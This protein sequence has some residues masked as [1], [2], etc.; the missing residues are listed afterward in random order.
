MHR[1]GKSGCEISIDHYTE[2]VT[3]NGYENGIKDN[4]MLEYRLQ[5]KDC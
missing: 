2:N 1:R 5:R 3:G 4:P